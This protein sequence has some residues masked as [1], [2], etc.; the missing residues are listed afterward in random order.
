MPFY[1]VPF[2]GSLL[3]EADSAAR[4]MVEAYK[5]TV[6]MRQATH[7]VEIQPVP[8]EI[9]ASEYCIERNRIRDITIEFQ[10][11]IKKDEE[12]ARRNPG[13][14]LIAKMFCNFSYYVG[15]QSTWEGFEW[16]RMRPEGNE[17]AQS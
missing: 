5:W 3:L 7:G 12:E 13:G 10:E 17:L 6:S 8:P 15:L 11:F 16:E 4:A 14:R 2:F 9:K 1:R